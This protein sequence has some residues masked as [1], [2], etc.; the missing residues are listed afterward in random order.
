MICPTCGS[1]NADAEV[2][3]DACGKDLPKTKP[4]PLIGRVAGNY[5]IKSKLGEGGMG[6]VYIAEHVALGADY[7]VKVLSPQ[8]SQNE[9]FRE[10]FRREGVT[11]C[12]IRHDNV[13]FVTDFGW[14][15]DIGSYLVMEYLEGLPLDAE[16]AGG[17]R[18]SDARVVEIAA[19]IAAA[20]RAAHEMKVVH[21]DLKPANVFVLGRKEAGERIKVLDFGIAKVLEGTAEEGLTS[22]G[23]ALGTPKYMAP[24]QAAGQIDRIGTW[25]DIYS[26]GVILFELLSG[27]APF[28]APSS[29][30]MMFN[31]VQQEAPPISTFRPELAG[32]EVETVLARMLAKDPDDR[33]TDLLQVVATLRTL[34]GGGSV[35]EATDIQ[36]NA[37]TGASE[38]EGV[39]PVTGDSLPF[40]PTLAATAPEAPGGPFE[41][42]SAVTEPG[43]DGQATSREQRTPLAVSQSPQERATASQTTGMLASGALKTGELATTD[44]APDRRTRGRLLTAVSAVAALSAVVLVGIV[45]GPGLVEPAQKEGK[46]SL[47]ALGPKAPSSPPRVAKR[48]VPDLGPKTAGTARKPPADTEPLDA[49]SPMPPSRSEPDG[50]DREAK[51]KPRQRSGKSKR[52]ARRKRRRTRRR[53][54]RRRPDRRKRRRRVARGRRDRRKG[55]RRKPIVAPS[56]TPAKP[57]PAR[58]RSC[59]LTI[60]T[61]PG[62]RISVAGVYAGTVGIKA[63]NITR[64]ISGRASPISV[65]VTKS[66]FLP[67]T[68]S[69]RPCHRKPSRHWKAILAP[70]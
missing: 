7:V 29:Q 55:A 61:G 39:S 65:K 53:T 26:F 64:V 45:Y 33:P 9:Q 43:L 60:F 19:Q 30:A 31:H 44:G 66:G 11:A 27:R 10:R 69:W 41:L 24:E 18:I 56:P 35:G 32:S 1:D 4:D 15:E 38:P 17:L 46:P 8:L 50:D 48:S 57:T 6:A 63:F 52:T 13:V 12:R 54:R 25:T 14:D 34:L 3:C 47:L 36:R 20:L 67:R 37:G 40:E 21:R 59:T 49:P 58:K 23:T 68:F 28:E 16:M 22:T 2:R 62:A 51:D 70:E 42:S 5:R